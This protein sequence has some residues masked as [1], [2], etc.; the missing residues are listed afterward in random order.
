MVHYFCPTLYPRTQAVSATLKTLIGQQFQANGLKQE[1][2][3]KKKN[4]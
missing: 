3:F 2:R 1:F 4:W